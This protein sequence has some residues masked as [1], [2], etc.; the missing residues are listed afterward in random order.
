[1]ELEM[2]PGTYVLAV[3]GGVDSVV[4]LDMLRQQKGIGLVVAHFDHGIRT[5]SKEDQTF[6]EALAIKYGLKFYSKI[7]KLGPNASE[8]LAREKRYNFLEQTR[9]QVSA[10]AIITAH[11]QDDILETAILNLLRGT[12]RRGLSSLRSTDKIIRPLLPLTK[13]DILAYAKS[14]NLT[15]REDSTNNDEKYL[16]NYVRRQII[17]KLSPTKRDELL[18]IVTKA[19]SS[20]QVIDEI[21]QQAIEGKVL[22]SEMNRQWFI[23]LPHA[24]AKEVMA[25]WLLKNSVELDRRRIEELVLA[26]KTLAANKQRDIDAGHILKIKTDKLALVSRER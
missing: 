25:T 13:A 11:H 5:D 22:K 6:V 16:R 18:D 15:W 17:P 19:Q 23:C 26:S 8:A 3:S 24:T 2:M 12:G 10:L 7:A 9:Q 20:N 14:H 21:L 4:L 1:M